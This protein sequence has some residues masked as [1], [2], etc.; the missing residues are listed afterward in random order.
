MKLF[1]VVASDGGEDRD[2]Q[3]SFMTLRG[4]PHDAWESSARLTSE[5][6][7]LAYKGCVPGAV[8]AK[9]WGT[10]ERRAAVRIDEEDGNTNDAQTNESGQIPPERRT[11]R[12]AH[13]G[14]PSC[15]AVSSGNS[16]KCPTAIKTQIKVD[17]VEFFSRE[18]EEGETPSATEN[19]NETGH[20]NWLVFDLAYDKQMTTAE[21]GGLTRQVTMC[22]A[23][24]R[25]ARRPFRI[26]VVGGDARD[27]V[28][29]VGGSETK[30]DGT[31]AET[32]PGALERLALNG[33]GQPSPAPVAGACCE[34]FPAQNSND[35]TPYAVY[36]DLSEPE[37][38]PSWRKLPWRSWG[39]ATFGP[40]ALGNNFQ[41]FLALVSG[42]TTRQSAQSEKEPVKVPKRLV[43]LSADA[44][45]V[46]ESILSGDVFILGGVVD[47]SEKPEFALRRFETIE[48]TFLFH[49]FGARREKD[50]G[51]SPPSVSF[52][53]K[54]LPIAG[55]I[56]LA[57]NAHL[58]C[59][60]VAQMLL[61][62]RE[63]CVERDVERDATG[64]GDQD[65][66][67]AN[68]VRETSLRETSANT[69]T[70]P[71]K[72]GGANANLWGESIARTPA[73][74]CA[75]LRKYVRWAPPH[76]H[77]NSVTKGETKPTGVTEVRGLPKLG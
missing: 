29:C 53:T 3:L 60:A 14:Q 71:P 33:R 46:L 12:C 13:C 56:S 58:T 42:G 19:Q 6:H 1:F 43:Y 37:K 24:N 31:S 76:E 62:F 64:E 17:K 45:E 70:W 32:L 28:T 30:L 67:G 35:D 72:E 40:S 26:A 27:D 65:D 49:D 66:A 22:V 74:R 75:P 8:I 7:A 48:K 4:E 16:V 25:R 51:A 44:T 50:A 18:D 11:R 59:L 23:A 61:V 9:V 55:H 52:V 5:A 36:H 20:E 54:R 10:L 39:A 69:F 73:F 21:H 57:K 15:I 63:V 77:L 34:T 38:G 2:V 41:S 47:H 68:S